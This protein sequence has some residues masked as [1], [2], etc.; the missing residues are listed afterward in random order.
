MVHPGADSVSNSLRVGETV[1]PWTRHQEH[2]HRLSACPEQPSAGGHYMRE[3][4]P[5]VSAQ[6]VPRH[7]ET[8]DDDNYQPGFHAQSY[9]GTH[10][11]GLAHP[12]VTRGCQE[13]LSRCDWYEAPTYACSFVFHNNPLWTGGLSDLIPR[14]VW[15]K[16]RTSKVMESVTLDM[17][18]D[19]VDELSR[20][21]HWHKQET[22]RQARAHLSRTTLA[23]VRR[24]PFPPCTW[25]E[26]KT[27]LMKRFQPK[28]LT[29]TYKA[30]FRSHRR[31]QKKDIYTY[32]ETLQHLADLAWPFMDY[33]D[34]EEMVVD[35]FL[36]GMGNH[37]FSVQ[38]AAHG[39]RHMEDIL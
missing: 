10:E 27:L 35:Q 17:F 38:V 39:H 9:F 20:L 31:R 6:S 29:A 12:D 11:P 15:F 22:C 21:Y 19:Q 3:S 26:L 24:A 36:L 33:H 30:Q 5:H 8:S 1:S 7:V 32:V 37:E 34:K 16:C 14:C 25:E 28:Y 2:A 4:V 13:W 23:Y 18:S